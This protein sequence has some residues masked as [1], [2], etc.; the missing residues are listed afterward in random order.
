M[1]RVNKLNKYDRYK[2]SNGSEMIVV[3]KILEYVN[4]MKKLMSDEN[5]YTHYTHLSYFSHISHI[6]HTSY[7]KVPHSW[8]YV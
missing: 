4:I 8:T 3:K 2:D 5:V 6:S 1:N 7:F